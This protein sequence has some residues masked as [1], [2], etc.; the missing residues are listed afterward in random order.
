MPEQKSLI[1]QYLISPDQVFFLPLDIKYYEYLMKV[2]VESMEQSDNGC[3]ST[4]NRNSKSK[5]EYLL[6]PN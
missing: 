4:L 3:L 2:S 5:M 1:G 6:A